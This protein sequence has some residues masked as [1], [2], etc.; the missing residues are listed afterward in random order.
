MRTGRARRARRSRALPKR[1]SPEIEASP[2]YKEGGLI[3]ITSA[4]ARRTGPNPMPAPAASP[5]PTRTCPPRSGAADAQPA[6]SSRSGG[7]GRVGLLL[8]SPFVDP[9]SVNETGYY[10]H[11]SLLL[12]IEEL[13]EVT[14]LGY[15]AEEA[16][17]AFDSSVFNSEEAPA[18]ATA[19]ARSRLGSKARRLPRRSRG[20][21]GSS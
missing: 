20:G 13:F 12:S 10:N 4:Q 18:A 5:P 7:G 21:R 15:A 1:S 11:Y 19:P 16:L 2:A 3:A 14:K 8:L 9:G 6:R 17:T